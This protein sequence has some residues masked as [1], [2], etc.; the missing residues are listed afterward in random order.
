MVSYAL[1][2]GHSV[3]D[4]RPAHGEEPG[5]FWR[6]QRPQPGREWFEEKI[7]AEHGDEA[8]HLLDL[9]VGAQINL[10]IFPNLLIIG[11]QVQVIEPLGVDRTQLTWHATR[12]DGVPEV[13]N[14]SRMRTQEDFPAFGEPDDQ[15]NFEEVQ[16]G[17]AATEA[18]WIVMNRGLDVD[19]LAVDRR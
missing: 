13:V 2:N 16:R 15:A 12:V 10:S 1:G 5:N 11:N 7:R 3:I 18:E 9:A 6:N 8:D 4:Q 19:G 17:L 14:T